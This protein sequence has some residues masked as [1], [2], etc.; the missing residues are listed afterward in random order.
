MPLL[1]VQPDNS[2]LGS[3]DITKSDTY[4]LTLRSDVKGIK[5]LRL[6]ALP[7]DSLPGH[8]P[9]MAFYEG[10]KGDFFMGEFQVS[11][12]GA[13]VKIASATESYS[14]NNF[15]STPVN[16][17]LATDGDPQTGWSCAGR[18]GERSEAVFVLDKP[19]NAGEIRLKMM[20][21]RHFACPL[22]RFRISATSETGGAPAVPA[23]PDDVDRSGDEVK[24][25]P[26]IPGSARTAAWMN[27]V[28]ALYASAEFRFVR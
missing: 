18:Y 8:G 5:A 12:N 24:E 3:G 16:A 26:V 19:L 1:S 4:E 11:A 2:V 15:G 9:G 27:F 13:P 23:N 22:G 25:A 10:P 17:M 28:Q 6:E 7:D 14:K 20:F 21:G